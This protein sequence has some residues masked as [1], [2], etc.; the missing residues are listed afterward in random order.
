MEGA[1]CRKV[2]AIAATVLRASLGRAAR[3][4]SH[5][6]VRAERGDLRGQ[7]ETVA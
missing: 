1:A 4:V 7:I 6:Q 5:C 2:M 3:L